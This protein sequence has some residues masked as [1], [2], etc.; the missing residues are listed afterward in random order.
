MDEARCH[1]CENGFEDKEQIIGITDA[2][3][4]EA[5]FAIV[6]SDQPWLYL[7]HKKCW[8]IIRNLIKQVSKP[9][10]AQTNTPDNDRQSD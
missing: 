3:V 5:D 6:P 9:S 1:R 8:G 7:Y 10:D 4:S 2:T